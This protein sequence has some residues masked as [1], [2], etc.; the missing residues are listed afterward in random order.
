MDALATDPTTPNP[1]INVTGNL[2]A[3][4]LAD[5]FAN[6]ESTDLRVANVFMNAKDFADLRKLDRDTIDSAQCKY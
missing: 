6:V 4:V 2:T 3:N 1:I 5:A